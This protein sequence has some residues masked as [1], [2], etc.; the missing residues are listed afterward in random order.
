MSNAQFVA[1]V[2]ALADAKDG[3]NC[4]QG[5]FRTFQAALAKYDSRFRYLKELR[6]TALQE[7]TAPWFRLEF[8]T[9]IYEFRLDVGHSS[10][11]GLLTGRVIISRGYEDRDEKTP[12]SEI[13]YEQTG[14]VLSGPPSPSEFK[15]NLRDDG[16]CRYAAAHIL[17]SDIL[18]NLNLPDA[19]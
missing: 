19:L 14:Y 1:V 15:S 18:P 13:E 4:I 2:D 11:S 3:L 7:K 12:I 17:A 5:D 10:D 8:L 6:I 9:R 16:Y